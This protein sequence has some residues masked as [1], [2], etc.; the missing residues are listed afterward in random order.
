M[1]QVGALWACESPP[2]SG[3]PLTISIR[4]KKMDKKEK[5][6]CK[7]HTLAASFLLGCT[8]TDEEVFIT[9]KF[10]G[11]DSVG[12]GDIVSFKPQLN[13]TPP[14]D[15]VPNPAKWFAVFPKLIARG[16]LL[17]NNNPVSWK[18]GSD[19]RADFKAMKSTV[20]AEV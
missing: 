7:V 13:L 2:S 10:V 19:S 3:L 20:V 14:T 12:F 15:K 9:R 8:D 4:R 17:E 11:M 5:R 1:R 18:K 16:V 6:W